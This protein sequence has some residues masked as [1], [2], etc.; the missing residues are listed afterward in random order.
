V[1]AQVPEPTWR[2]RQISEWT[3]ADAK[4][5]LT[6]S[7]WAKTATP[8]FDAKASPNPGAASGGIKIGGIGV[9]D[10]GGRA[11]RNKTHPAPPKPAQ[12][13]V[14]KLR[15]ESALPIR[16]AELKAH[17]TGAPDMQG[18]FYA[19]AV[20]GLPRSAVADDSKQSAE[21]IKKQAVLK[22]N[23]MKDVR[24][25]SVQ[26]LLRDDGPIIVY[27]FSKSGDFTWRDHTIQFE[28]QV[29]EWKFTQSF[30]TDDMMFHGNLEL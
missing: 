14:L 6:D 13:P 25:S 11:H 24:P 26:I 16:E 19:I 15:W 8:T 2:G 30:S 21:A 12:P 5:V 17:D 3:E 1:A 27:R 28:A 23:V 9:P 7:P 29:A 4:Q 22:R 10:L 18:G 20:Y